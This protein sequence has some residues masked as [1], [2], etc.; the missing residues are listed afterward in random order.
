MTELCD[1][2]IFWDALNRI[3]AG[4]PLIVSRNM[5]ITYDLVALEAGRTR[6]APINLLRGGRK[7]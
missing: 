5:P 2:I 1:L 6:D 4:K 3:L 7:S